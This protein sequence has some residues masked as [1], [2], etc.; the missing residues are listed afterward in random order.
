MTP[1][2]P[3]VIRCG[4][5]LTTVLAI[6]ACSPAA[7]TF[8]DKERAPLAQAAA[9]TSAQLFAWSP[10]GESVAIDRHGLKILHLSSGTLSRSAVDNARKLAWGAPGLALATA[11]DEHFRLYLREYDGEAREIAAGEGV[12]VDLKW[13]GDK[14]FA[15]VMRQKYFSFGINQRSFLLTWQRGA[16]IAE[17]L[18]ADATLKPST[19]RKVGE[20]FPYGPYLHISPYGDE[21]VYSRLHDPPA[22]SVNYRV[23]VRHL[24]SGRERMLGSHALSGGAAAIMIDGEHLL[25]SDGEYQVKR[26]AIWGKGQEKY[27][28]SSAGDL[29]AAGGLVYAAG[30]L[31][32]DRERLWALPQAHPAHFSPDGSQLAILAAGQL[33]IVSVQRAVVRPVPT[34]V[35]LKLRRL[36]ALGLITPVEYR[37]YMKE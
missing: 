3:I 31:Y 37:R 11:Q 1:F 20:H 36:R 16:D 8:S 25:L 17:E 13:S 24:A 2:V 23:A 9:I 18:L 19:P 5:L 15:L 21:I 6:A 28:E 32:R 33:Y 7:L 10:D 27:F 22:F 4:L 34:S 35:Q 12:V 29:V 14:L 26:I 30:H